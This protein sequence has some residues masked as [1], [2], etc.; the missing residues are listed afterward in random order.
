M[1]VFTSGQIR[2][3]TEEEK[4]AARAGSQ[5]RA[6]LG[7]ESTIKWAVDGDQGEVFLKN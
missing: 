3:T 6:A 7:L 2:E 1:C 4:V 5:L